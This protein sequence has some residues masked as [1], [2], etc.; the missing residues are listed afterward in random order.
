MPKQQN[1]AKAK[2]R[3]IGRGKKKD[4]GRG[5]ALALFVRNKIS[6]EEYFRQTGQKV[7]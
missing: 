1:K 4:A 6:G 5:S 3:K 7:K 2:G